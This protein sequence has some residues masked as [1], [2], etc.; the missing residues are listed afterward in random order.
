MDAELAIVAGRIDVLLLAVR[1]ADSIA[2]R[3]FALDALARGLLAADPGSVDTKL[4]DEARALRVDPSTILSAST[5]RLPH[6]VA[7]VLVAGEI[8]FVRQLYVTFDPAGLSREDFFLDLDAR[9]AVSDAI[10]AAA[11]LAPPPSDPLLHCLAAAHPEVLRRAR[12]E[13]R[14]LSAAAFVSACALWMNR[15]LRSDVAVSAELR[16]GNLLGVGAIAVKVNAALAHRIR[17]FI[18]VASDEAAARAAL[19]VGAELEIVGVR[20]MSELLAAA[21]EEER[22]PR[23]S[24]AQAIEEARRLSASAWVGY[25]WPSVRER[26]ARISGTLPA[27]RVDLRVEVLARLAAAQ[28]HL[29]DPL[30][31]HLILREA[32]ALA[33]SADGKLGVPDAPISYLYQQLAMTFRQ[34]CNFGR[35]ARA[36][37]RAVHVARSARLRG[38]LTKAL[39]CVGL[40][41]LGRNRID[42]AIAAFA[43]SLEVVLAHDPD[44]TARTHAYLI[45]AL[46]AARELERAR[47][48]Y[49]TAME[50]L[51]RSDDEADRRARESWVRTSFGGA[52]VRSGHADE[53]IDVLDVPAVRVSL[54]EEPLPGL[55]ARRYLGIALSEVGDRRGLE[56]LAA[57]P[58]VHGRALEPHLSF[59]AHLNVLY[60][61]RL[62]FGAGAWSSDI[63]G[64]ALRAMAQIPRHGRVSAFLGPTRGEARRLIQGKSERVGTL[65][66]L[67]ERCS[68]LG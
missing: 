3:R 35:A 56:L 33:T 54:A 34:L 66:A 36:A 59:L 49:R 46:G 41:A 62:R 27:Y 61:A 9:R 14:S 7:V 47:G 13:G 8:G 53:A 15:P 67:L 42:E 37:Q 48:H 39:G 24:P 58:L 29:G 5:P 10:V 52:L 16:N 21:L 23:V 63:Q 19:A 26:L 6:A 31:S 57:S 55:L 38:E 64:R 40:V 18:V 28:R 12:V 51:E 45:E 50:E 22:E 25:R 44:H 65:D 43:E 4:C 11:Q 20:S 30:G 32:E 60:E 1:T 17:R 2:Q 68:R